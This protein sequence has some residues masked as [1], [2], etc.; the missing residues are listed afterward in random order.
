MGNAEMDKAF[1]RLAEFLVSDPK[2]REL[3]NLALQARARFQRAQRDEIQGLAS[4]E[5]TKLSY[6]QATRQALQVVE[7]LEEG[8]LKPESGFAAP[9]SRR[10]PIWAGAL[11]LLLALAGGGYWWHQSRL[12]EPEEPQSAAC[13]VAFNASS[14]FNIL[15]VP[16]QALKGEKQLTHITIAERLENFA[17]A[18]NIQC[19]F[20][21]FPNEASNRFLSTDDAANIADG[22]KAQLIIWGTTESISNN[23]TIVNTRYKFVNRGDQ[24][25]LSKLKLTENT[26]LD[27]VT[28]IS[29]IATSGVLTEKIEESIKLLFGLIAH[30]TGN[31]PA[32]IDMLEE[33]QTQDSAASLVKGMVLAQD[34]LASNQD[35]KAWESYNQVL[36]QHP[37]YA[38]ARNNR[39][40][41][42]YQKGNYAEAAEDLSVAL[43]KD[44]ANAEVLEIRGS[45]YFKSDQLENAREDLQKA[46]TLRKAPDRELNQKIEEVDQKIE[47]EKKAKASAEAE[48]RVNPNNLAAWNQKAI[49]SQKLGDY[50]E[51]VKASEA[52][53]QRDR[54]NE[55]AFVKIIQAY[56]SAGEVEKVKE[57][58]QRAEAAGVSRERLDELAPFDL[59][60]LPVRTK[61]FPLKRN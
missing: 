37:D 7:W 13:P 15:L 36:E 23:N 9:R 20:E 25:P 11:A 42:N 1:N 44:S 54:D 28:S 35:D 26:K 17:K 30:E 46:K 27:T 53:L 19:D 18:Y 59:S 47:E 32:A 38:L 10:W 14:L 56:R 5:Q 41:L 51:A 58:I 52:I 6:N 39:G 31:W 48:L 49:S 21:T 40:V 60:R 12:P 8:N 4:S 22:C 43:E 34:Y 29:S 3:H 33:Y 50:S 24:L 57:T 2:Y 55:A 16:F 45:A 61:T